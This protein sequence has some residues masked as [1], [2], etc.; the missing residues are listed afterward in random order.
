MIS[1]KERVMKEGMREESKEER[2]EVEKGEK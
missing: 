2:R 1:D